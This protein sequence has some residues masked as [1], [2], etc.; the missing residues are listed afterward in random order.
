MEITRLERGV[1]KLTQSMRAFIPEH[2]RKRPKIGMCMQL[3]GQTV[4]SHRSFISKYNK[5][6][7][8]DYLT[9]MI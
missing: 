6:T 2:L 7:T 5:S 4:T 8:Y 1:E 3:G 9:L